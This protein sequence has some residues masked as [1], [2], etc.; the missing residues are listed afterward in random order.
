MGQLLQMHRR[1]IM[2][3][4]TSFYRLHGVQIFREDGSSFMAWGEEGT[5]FAGSF[6]RAHAYKRQLADEGRIS[7]KKMKV[8]KIRMTIEYTI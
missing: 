4:H 1:R 6:K 7:L 2:T 5:E 3:C 8:V